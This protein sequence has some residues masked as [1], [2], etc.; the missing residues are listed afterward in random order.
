MKKILIVVFL[1]IL[2]LLLTAKDKKPA[3]TPVN[4]N[5]LG[6]GFQIGD[7]FGLNF[8]LDQKNDIF[9][10]GVVGWS[11]GAKIH[12]KFDYL[13]NDLKALSSLNKPEGIVALYYGPGVLMRLDNSSNFMIGAEGTIGIDYKLT[14]APISIFLELSPA[15]VL[16][17]SVNI[18]MFGGLGARF[19]I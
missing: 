6:V 9:Y 17:P 13:W 1:V 8:R 19:F 10:E 2:P 18:T 15:L 12:V 4:T 11:G 7:P 3:D 16:T 5:N 14:G